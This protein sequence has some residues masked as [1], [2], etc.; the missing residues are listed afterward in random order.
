LMTLL[1]ITLLVT[2]ILGLDST[3]RR[4]LRMVGN[5]RD[6]FKAGFIA[7]SGLAAA[8]A[9]LKEDA[10]KSG[11]Y[12]GL[13]E[14]WANPFPP[15]PIGDGLIVAKIEDEGGKFNLNQVVK[16]SGEQLVI[17]E[18]KSDQ[19]KRMFEALE[20]DPNL[21]DAIV[22]WIDSDELEISSFGAEDGFYNSLERPYRAKNG[23]LSHL[24]ELHQIEGIS[25]Q[26]YWKIYPYLT[27]YPPIKQK[28]NVNTADLVILQ[29]FSHEITPEVA[30]RIME[31]R[32]Y[33][34]EV[35]FRNDIKAII[36]QELFIGINNASGFKDNF[37][38]KSDFYSVTS[39]GI[40]QDV[41]KTVNAVIERKGTGS[42]IRYWRMD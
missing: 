22:D 39:Q 2:L 21:V 35:D 31:S 24:S 33:E 11:Q 36:G 18:E 29:S 10:K 30:E 8:R 7:K 17:F 1:V 38:I 34:D 16:K 15:Y 42:V 9:V 28:I 20:V 23:Y 14:P 37:G 27:V 13:D 5:L 12:D 4:E 32:P 3:V 19:L 26:I 40:V 41:Q 25:D 6:D